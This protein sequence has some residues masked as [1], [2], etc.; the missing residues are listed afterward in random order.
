[1]SSIV[2]VNVVAT[3]YD[4]VTD[5]TIL[6]AQ[7]RESRTLDFANVL[8]IMEPKIT[9][10]MSPPFRKLT[11]EEDAAIVL[12]LAESDARIL[13]VGLGCPKQ[14]KLMMEHAGR[15]LAVMYGVGAPFD[16]IAGAKL[17]APRWMMRTGLEWAFRFCA[18]PRRLA[19]YIRHSRRSV[20]F[21]ARQMILGP[22]T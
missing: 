4:E 19:H 22:R 21:F 14:E 8:V 16:F 13:F 20:F 10:A 6:W 5:Q 15:I 9:F 1:L 3:N 18:E 11:D 7:G 17:Q 12:E 2:G